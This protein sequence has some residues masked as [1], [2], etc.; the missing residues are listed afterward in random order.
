MNAVFSMSSG[1]A[2]ISE[3][4]QMAFLARQAAADAGV[5]AGRAGEPLPVEQRPDA[6]P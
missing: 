2:G 6:A 3:R 1:G 5:A 4:D